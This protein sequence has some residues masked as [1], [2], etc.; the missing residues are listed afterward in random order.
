[1]AEQANP[2]S[3]SQCPTGHGA[4]RAS[5]SSLGVADLEDPATIAIPRDLAWPTVTSMATAIRSKLCF[6]SGAG[7]SLSVPSSPNKEWNFY[8]AA[9]FETQRGGT[10]RKR[11]S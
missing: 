1:M 3:T 4:L 7:G 6:V 5:S 10:R 9:P 2:I 11:W 8:P